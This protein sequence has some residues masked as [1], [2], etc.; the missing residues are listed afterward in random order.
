[1]GIGVEPAT[2]VLIHGGGSSAWD[3][4]LVEPE[5]RGLGHEVVA[6]DLPIEDDANGISEYAD[7]VVAECAGHRRLAVVAH[8][9]GG[10][11]APLVCSRVATELLVFVAG[12]VPKPGE[13][14][15][16]WWSAT[17]HDDLGIALD[18]RREEVDAFFNGVPDRLVDA[19][20]E[21]ARDQG[22]ANWEQPSPLRAWPQVPTRFLLCRDDRFFPPDFARAHATER[23][24]ITPDE[25]DGG[26]MVALAH[27][28]ELAE[29]LHGF[30][31]RRGD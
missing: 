26:H 12:M 27:P 25:I 24:G 6:V 20:F 29:R 2:F 4:H 21:H 18:T 11:V 16:E 30:W 3:W 14:P 17:G 1:M 13:S 31:N 28:R 5:L 8:S 9:F 10:L 7:A 19:A 22:G 15:A 23:L